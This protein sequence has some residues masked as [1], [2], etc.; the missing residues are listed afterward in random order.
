MRQLSKPWP[1]ANV[2]RDGQPARRFI[3]AEQEFLAALPNSADKVA[4]ARASYEQLDKPKLRAVMYREQRYVCVYCE[5]AISETQPP[6]TI[7]H[8]RPLSRHHDYALHWKNLYLSCSTQDTCNSSKGDSHLRW[9]AADPDLPWPTELAYENI[10]GFTRGGEVYVRQDVNIDAAT[11][12]ALELAIDDCQDGAQRRRGILNLNYPPLREARKAA[13][14]AERTRIEH[15]FSNRRA[16]SN[17]REYRATEM[18]QQGAAPA[19]VSIRVAWL[20]GTLG[21][22]R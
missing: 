9:D 11:R 1:P 6:P 8:W 4:F 2:S 19:Y 18:L 21:R 5:R 14:D 13:L 7:E 20:R 17:E 16:S 15:D 22:G 12:R 10:I 3:D